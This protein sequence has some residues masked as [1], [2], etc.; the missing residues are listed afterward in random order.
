M[1][2]VP[3]PV[4]FN[5]SLSVSTESGGGSPVHGSASPNPG[6]CLASPGSSSPLGMLFLIFLV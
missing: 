5:H 1:H 4:A 6:A 2:E 3:A